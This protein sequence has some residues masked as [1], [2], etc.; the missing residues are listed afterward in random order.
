LAKS[1]T[2][3]YV[4]DGLW[5]RFKSDSSKR[6]MDMSKVLEDLIID[7]LEAGDF[8]SMLTAAKSSAVELEFKPIRLRGPP[9]SDLI[10]GQRDE[11]ES[12]LSR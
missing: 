8:A 1:K 5:K 9:V 3:I 12:H 11:R 2:S 7:E 10:R 4:D 6:G